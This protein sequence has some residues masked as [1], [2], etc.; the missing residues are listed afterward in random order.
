MSSN[1]TPEGKDKKIPI[2]RV[3]ELKQTLLNEL[4]RISSESC[5]TSEKAIVQR[6]RLEQISIEISHLNVLMG[7]PEVI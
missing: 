2:E 6:V 5:D 3:Q 7:L 1:P 4:T